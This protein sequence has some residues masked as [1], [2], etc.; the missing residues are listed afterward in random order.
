M[1]VSVDDLDRFLIRCLQDDPRATYATIARM[2]DVSETTVKRR[3]EAL[4]EG[5]VITTAVFPNP[6]LLGY[7]VQASIGI[8]VELTKVETIAFTVRDFPEVAYVAMALGRYDLLV[9]V[10]VP[11]VSDLTRF[12][13]ERIA[14][15]PGIKDTETVITPRV[16]K[17]FANWRVPI[18]GF[19]PTPPTPDEVY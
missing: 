4:M 1:M 19:T 7:Q 8:S 10:V 5:G 14:P 6:R 11:T 15:I 2:T 3:I 12:M 18:D 9:Y 13:M 16:Y 17:A